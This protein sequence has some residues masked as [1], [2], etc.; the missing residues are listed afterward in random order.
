MTARAH[1][2][3]G[4][5]DHDRVVTLAPGESID[6]LLREMA[7]AGFRWSL[8]RSAEPVLHLT[9][10]SPVPPGDTGVG[11]AGA[12]RFT[13]EAG[14]VGDAELRLKLWRPTVGDASVMKRF[15]LRVEVRRAGG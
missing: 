8:D 13:F 4:E 3:L 7:G 5:A 15:G 1:R 12:R 11:A 14:T 10:D 6:V 9:G 2:E